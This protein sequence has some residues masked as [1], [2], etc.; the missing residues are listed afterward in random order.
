MESPA[1]DKMYDE[2]MGFVLR[3]IAT[4]LSEEFAKGALRNRDGTVY[5]QLVGGN[6]GARLRPFI[7]GGGIFAGLPYMFFLGERGIEVS[8]FSYTAGESASIIDNSAASAPRAHRPPHL[9]RETYRN[10]AGNDC[11]LKD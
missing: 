10:Y 5:S 4:F 2:I 11:T 1:Q 6:N 8:G 7:A 3:P 9:I